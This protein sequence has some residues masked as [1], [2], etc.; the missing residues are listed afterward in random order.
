MPAVAIDQISAFVV[1]GL[2]FDRS[3]GRVGWGRGHYDATFS[4]SR[5]GAL[6][7]GVAFDCQI[8]DRITRESHDALVHVLVS[9]S[10]ILT[11]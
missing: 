5:A 10:T 7:I 8:V 9:E 4:R 6:R 2:G 1:P 11:V 3:G